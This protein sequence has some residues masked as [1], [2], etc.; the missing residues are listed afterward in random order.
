METSKV[1]VALLLFFSLSL[2]VTVTSHVDNED[3]DI[4]AI[5]NIFYSQMEAQYEQGLPWIRQAHAKQHG[6]IKGTMSVDSNLPPALAQG[7]FS[8]ETTYPFFIRFSNGLGRGFS[9]SSTNN[10]SDSSLDTRGMALKFFG[11]PG[12]KFIQPDAETQDLLMTTSETGFIPDSS[13]GRGFFTAVSKGSLAFNA[14]L[15]IHPIVA[16]GYIKF[17]LDGRISNLLVPTWYSQAAYRFGSSI[18]KFRVDPTD[19][20]NSM[21]PLMKKFPVNKRAD[22][23]FLREALQTDLSNAP[24]CFKLSVQLYVDNDTTPIDDTTVA[25]PTDV[26]PVA[27][28]VIPIQSF[29]TPGQESFCRQMSFNPW[30]SIAEHEP[31]GFIGRTRKVIY[32]KGAQQRHGY[33]GQSDNEPTMQDWINYDNL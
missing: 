33:Y 17:G 21:V 27:T 23:N 19:C 16:A 8:N 1:A 31:L 4:A 9:T 30:H 28:L 5:E 26:N 32:T 12:D 18:G 14:W 2:S 13:T 25:W 10:G 22:F 6:C 7:I 11:V 29:G 15:L 3:D 20:P 24:A